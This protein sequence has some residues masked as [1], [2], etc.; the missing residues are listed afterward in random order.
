MPTLWNETGEEARAQGKRLLTRELITF[1]L[2]LLLPGLAR[3][4]AKSP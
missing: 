3:R 2:W 4:G 1:V